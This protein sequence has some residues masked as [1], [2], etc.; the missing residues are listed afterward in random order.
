MAAGSCTFV[1]LLGC[2]RQGIGAAAVKLPRHAFLFGK[3]T[4]VVFSALP[5]L[6]QF[7]AMLLPV[8]PHVI[9]DEDVLANAV[10]VPGIET[11]DG[12]ILDLTGAQYIVWSWSWHLFKARC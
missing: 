1:E 9:A 11:H 12:G 2:P 8:E 4:Q 6:H 5:E 7:F 10:A 3:E